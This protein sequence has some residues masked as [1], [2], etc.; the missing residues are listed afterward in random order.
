MHKLRDTPVGLGFCHFALFQTRG[1]NDAPPGR[2]AILDAHTL[3]IR[4]KTALVNAGRVH[5]DA[6]FV[7]GKTVPHDRI[8]RFGALTADFANPGHV[9]VLLERYLS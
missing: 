5:A 6:A 7:L 1:A 2:L 9:L 4:Q 3:Q 8:A